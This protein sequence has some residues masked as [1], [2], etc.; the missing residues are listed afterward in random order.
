MQHVSLRQYQDDLVSGIYAHFRAGRLC[1]LAQSPVGSGKTRAAA[2]V[3]SD[4]LSRGRRV[5]FLAHRKELVTQPRDTLAAFDIPAGIIKAGFEFE[6]DLPLQIASVQTLG[7]RL[8]LIQEPDLIVVDEAHHSVA[9]T[10]DRILAAFP[11]ARVLGLS[12]T[13]ERTDGVGLADTF[14]VMVEGPD[15]PWLVEQGFLVDCDV[16]GAPDRMILPRSRG[17]DYDPKKILRALERRGRD[18]DPLVHFRRHQQPGMRAV[19]FGPSVEWCEEQAERFRAAG[20]KAF[21]LSGSTRDEDRDAILNGYATGETDIVW[22]VD[23]IG[24]GTDIPSLEILIDCAKTK[25][26]VRYIQRAGRILRPSEGKERGIYIDLV[27]NVVEH[28]HPCISRSWSLDGE[29]GRTRAD[30]VTEDGEHLSTRQCKRCDAN[31]ATA[32]ECP[33]CGHDNGADTR[34]SKERAAEIRKLEKDELAAAKKEAARARL[35]EERACQSLDELKALGFR[36]GYAPGWA[37]RRWNTMGGR[38]KPAA[39]AIGLDGWPT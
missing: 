6:P 28:G 3:I 9:G 19:G 18:G 39:P 33:Y 17:A 30:Q 20:Y 8:D 23:V 2:R 5:L 13:P 32:P 26:L 16:F 36:R 37:Y 38:S 15:I 21:C 31:Y 7:N 14:E 27:G 22:N 35:A 29:A 1:V 11:D 25:S 10:W 24:E 34:I 4:A 12:G